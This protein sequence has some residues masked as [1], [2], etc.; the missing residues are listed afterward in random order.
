[1][2]KVRTMVLHIFLGLRSIAL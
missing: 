1:M 2:S